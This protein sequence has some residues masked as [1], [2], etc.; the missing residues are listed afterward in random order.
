MSGVSQTLCKGHVQSSNLM[1]Q[2]MEH[3]NFLMLGAISMLAFA[4]E[5]IKSDTCLSQMARTGLRPAL[6][7]TQPMVGND[8]RT[9]PDIRPF[10]MPFP[11]A[12]LIWK[13]GRKTPQKLHGSLGVI[14]V[15]P[16]P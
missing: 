8:I 4:A 16:A 12:N 2:I 3:I 7:Q 5:N 1:E 11:I 15:Y 13:F 10:Q 6:R 9:I 14:I